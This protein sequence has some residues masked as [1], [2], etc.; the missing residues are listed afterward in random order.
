MS[1]ARFDAAVQ[2]VLQHE[3]GLVDDPADPGGLTN[4]GISIRDYPELGR[5]GITN[6]TRERAASIYQTDWWM[7]YRLWCLPDPVAGKMLDL[8]VNMGIGSATRCLQ[9]A[10]NAGQATV[11]VD[12]V[13]GP[14]TLS[15][16]RADDPQALMDR[17]R[18]EAARHYESIVA[19]NPNL[20]R[21]AKGWQSRAFA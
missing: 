3:G 15:A 10:L 11:I 5:D 8:A 18:R 21:F 17:L 1:D 4:Y 13:I 19:S 7:R 2:I 14:S 9:R 16:A 20:E 12:G 6:M